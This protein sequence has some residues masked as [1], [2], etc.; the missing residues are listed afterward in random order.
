MHQMQQTPGTSSGRR[1][2]LL[3]ITEKNFFFCFSAFDSFAEGF[4][5]L[6][7]HFRLRRESLSFS[8]V[9]LHFDQILVHQKQENF[10]FEIGKGTEEGKACQ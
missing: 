3:S 9:R 5:S 2:L 8:R 1:K 10:F 7:V 6:T 4:F